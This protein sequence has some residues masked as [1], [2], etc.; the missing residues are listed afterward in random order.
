MY[1]P[2]VLNGV[3]NIIEENAKMHKGNMPQNFKSGMRKI[4]GMTRPFSWNWK[5]A[6]DLLKLKS[7]NMKGHSLDLE[8]LLY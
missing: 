1:I 7:I 5:K 3:R 6:G 4:L 8:I 2:N